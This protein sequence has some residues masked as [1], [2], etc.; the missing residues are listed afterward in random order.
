[1]DANFQACMHLLDRQ[2]HLPCE[3]AQAVSYAAQQGRVVC[4]CGVFYE[5]PEG[6]GA[7]EGTE[8]AAVEMADPIASALALIDPTQTYGP[9]EVEKHILDA[10]ARLESGALFERHAVEA[11][12]AAKV[13]FERAYWVA[14]EGADASA[15]D[16]RKGQAMTECLDLHEALIQAEAL[17]KCVKATMHNLRAILSGYQSVAKSVGAAYQ[18]GGAQ[19]AHTR[20]Y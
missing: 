2:G 18:G 12:A 8:V 19:H 20:P 10:L 16:R 9:D 6:F 4:G 17:E 13:A 3:W 11:A 1:M 5:A 15:A 7:Q 14:L